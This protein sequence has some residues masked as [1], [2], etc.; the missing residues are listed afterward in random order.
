[1]IASVTPQ[2]VSQMNIPATS[3]RTFPAS[4]VGMKIARIGMSPMATAV[5]TALA[6]GSHSFATI[7]MPS[8][9]DMML[10]DARPFTA[11]SG[12]ASSSMSFNTSAMYTCLMKLGAGIVNAPPST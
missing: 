11:R 2:A 1:M 4:G 12:F 10:L 6:T 7:P 5:I 8:P 9:P 3:P